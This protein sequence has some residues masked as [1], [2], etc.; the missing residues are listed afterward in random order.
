MRFSC[1]KKQK[2]LPC[3]RNENFKSKRIANQNRRLT[4]TCSPQNKFFIKDFCF[5]GG[6]NAGFGRKD[7]FAP[8]VDSDRLRAAAEVHIAGYELLVDL[9][10]EG[11]HFYPMV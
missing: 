9:L 10:G 4:Y 5:M 6:L 8:V 11:V 3:N 2:R 1:Y 7:Y